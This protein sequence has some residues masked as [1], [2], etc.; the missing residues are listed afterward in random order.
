ML[1]LSPGN[2][3][4]HAFLW[5]T[6]AFDDPPPPGLGGPCWSDGGLDPIGRIDIRPYE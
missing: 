2:S 1:I 5:I 3:Q 6:R 4:K